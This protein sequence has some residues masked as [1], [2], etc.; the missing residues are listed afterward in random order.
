MKTLHNHVILYD[1]DCPMCN[2]YTKAFVKTGMLD[3]NGRIPFSPTE[4]PQQVD[5]KRACDEIALV[6][7]ATHEVTYGIDSLFKILAHRF[8]FL[9]SLFK[10]SIFRAALSQLYAFI[11]FN[12]KVIAPAAQTT[13]SCTPSFNLSYRIA[14]LIFSW[15]LTSL[16][17]TSFATHLPIPATSFGR[18]FL[19]CGGQLLFQ[20]SV[21]WFTNRNRAFDYLG[22]MM[23]VSL[24]GGLMLLPMLAIHS[25]HAIP[26]FAFLVWFAIVVALMLFMH[27]HRV[28]L[29]QA[30]GWLTLTWIGFRILVLGII[31][32]Q[33]L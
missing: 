6:N 3:S 30:S 1:A 12:R 23:T 17:L 22:N 16:I 7:C 28:K 26:S 14:Y 9:N 31:L 10:L 4:L 21:V 24:I 29:L 19:I 15:V 25:L 8:T 5:V 13:S 20:G 11:S 32:H 33:T 2:L 18:E 27:M